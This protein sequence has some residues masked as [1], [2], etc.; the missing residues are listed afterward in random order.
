MFPVSNILKRRN[1]VKQNMFLDKK[2]KSASMFWIFVTPALFFYVVFFVVPLFG[3]FLLSFTSWNGL[4]N[5]YNFIG[6]N[7]YINM[8]TKDKDF[9]NSLIITIKFATI[10]VIIL[11]VV[12]LTFA[13]VFDS[14]IKF[15]NIYK[16]IVFLPNAVSLII[17]AFIWQFL[18]T[19]V[20]RDVAEKLGLSVFSWFETPTTAMVA[21]IITYL[22]HGSGYC[23]LL[24]VAGLQLINPEYWDAAEIDGANAWSKFW[25]ITLPMIMPSITVNLFISIAN[26]FKIFEIAFKMTQGGPGKS[27]EFLALNIY[28]EAF[29]ANRVGYAS[30]KAFVLFLLIM[31][32][33]YI[34]LK[35]TKSREVQV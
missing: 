1:N 2:L 19:G 28:R 16:S 10:Y 34:Q 6:F 26:S 11:N 21:V 7:N 3:N 9:I 29:S 35:I 5:E 22:W 31:L 23:M 14:K 25:H 13:L 12:G 18:F 27:T 15:K 4:T 30:A 24:Y 8:F 17:V 20:Y 33:T 32:V